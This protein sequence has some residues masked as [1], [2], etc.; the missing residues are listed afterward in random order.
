MDPRSNDVTPA[1]V[2]VLLALGVPPLPPLPL[3]V[4]V[5]VLEPGTVKAGF[6]ALRV[7]PAT[8]V[9]APGAK[10]VEAKLH[11]DMILSMSCGPLAR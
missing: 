7:I 3:L 11:C 5:G 4:P 8:A 9:V 1:E 10:V 6:V 2:P